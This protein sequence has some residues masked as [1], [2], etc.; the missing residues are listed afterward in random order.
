M[1]GYYRF[2]EIPKEGKSAIWKGE[3]V[4]G[5]EE[6]VSVYE[7]HINEDGFLVP[8][9]P[10]PLTE[11]TLDDFFYFLCYFRGRRYYVHGERI[12]TG[13]S[14]EPLIVPQVVEEIINGK[15]K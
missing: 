2:G 12:G 5:Y 8:V 14:G 3:E 11:K 6:G 9:L 4:I 7:C 15:L 13:S 10:F 1:N